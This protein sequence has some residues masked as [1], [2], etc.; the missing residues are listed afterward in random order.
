MSAFMVDKAHVIY[1]AQAAAKYG[2]Y[3]KGADGKTRHFEQYEN[4]R[5]I[6][7]VAN[8]LW[9]ENDR[10]VSHRYDLDEEKVKTLY[11]VSRVD[12][13]EARFKFDP[14]QVIKSCR[15]LDYQS[16]ECPDYEQTEAY[17]ITT[18]LVFATV[19]E[20]PGYNDLIWGSPEP[21]R[22]VIQ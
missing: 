15:C 4:E 7:E 11:V 8:I 3:W 9:K 22:E 18:A 21:L 5:L 12:C 16:C 1:L 19:N 17:R 14:L 10:S 2:I 6:A 13:E 20:L